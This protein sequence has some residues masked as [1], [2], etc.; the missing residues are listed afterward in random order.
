[1]RLS[2]EETQTPYTS[3]SQSARRWTEDWA[4]ANLYCP[5]CDADSLAALPNNAPVADLECSA[6]DEQYELKSS[7]RSFGRKVV[8]GAY[9]TMMTR[10]RSRQNPSLLLLNYDAEDLSVDNLIVIP[11]RLF[12]PELIEKRKPLAP[13]AR[14]AGWVGCNIIIDRLPRSAR[15]PMIRDR[16]IVFTKDVRK[17]W[18]KM[19]FLEEKADSAKGWLLDVLA[20]VESLDCERFSLADIYALEARLQ[21]LYPGNSNVRPKIRQQLQVLRDNGIIEFLGGGEYRLT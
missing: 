5:A 11:R 6:C 20:C 3:G 7:K 16:Q 18:R 9:A 19:A 2:F 1:M 21:A 17:Q 8:D 12:T 4:A 10:L 15:I 14:R 13:A